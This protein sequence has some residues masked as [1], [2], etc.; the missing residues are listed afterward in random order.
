VVDGLLVL[1]GGV[2]PVDDFEERVDEATA[3]RAVIVVV[4]VLPDVQREDGV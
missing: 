3:V 1:F 2:V 4:G